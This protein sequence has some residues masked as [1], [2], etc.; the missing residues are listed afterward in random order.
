MQGSG[1]HAVRD[2]PSC[3]PPPL[4]PYL[5]SASLPSISGCRSVPCLV[6]IAQDH[7][8][9][10][11][12]HVLWL[13]THSLEDKGDEGGL[14]GGECASAPSTSLLHTCPSPLLCA[15]NGLCPWEGGSEP[16]W[17]PLL[18]EQLS[19]GSAPCPSADPRGP[20]VGHSPLAL[21]TLGAPVPSLPQ[22][23]PTPQHRPHSCSPRCPCW[24]SDSYAHVCHHGVT[25]D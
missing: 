21:P 19:P 15:P 2:F 6:V 18:G 5:K 24:G 22:P 14:E 23:L 7:Q 3:P 1:Q 9:L 25:G 4:P 12:H 13:F 8:E 17:A 16:A 20:R 11:G 10:V